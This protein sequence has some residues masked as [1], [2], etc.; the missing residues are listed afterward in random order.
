MPVE[1]YVPP[2]QPQTQP[3]PKPDEPP[4]PDTVVEMPQIAT[5]VAVNPSQVRFAVPVEGPVVF[6][7]AQFAQA[8]PAVLPK[9]RTIQMFTGTDGGTYPAPT[10]PRAALEQRQQGTVTTIIAVNPDGSVESVEIK[11]SSG[12][13]TLDRHAS[14]WAK[15]RYKFPPIPIQE[16][17]YYEKDFEFNLK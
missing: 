4:P 6:A 3:E 12:Y 16:M 9:T 1:V 10:Y 2:V 11:K 13:V 14:Q 7:P 17:R 8:P 5:V 15:T